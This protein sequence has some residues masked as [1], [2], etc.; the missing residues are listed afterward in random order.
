MVQRRRMTRCGMGAGSGLET[1]Q[2]HASSRKREKETTG[3]NS[4]KCDE[5]QKN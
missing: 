4:R 3:I 2:H 5:D 1:N